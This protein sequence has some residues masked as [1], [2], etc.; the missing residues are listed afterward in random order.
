MPRQYA[1][2]RTP[3]FCALFVPSVPFCGPF[4]PSFSRALFVAGLQPDGGRVDAVA[5]PGGP[6]A[7]GENV[8]EMAPARLAEHLGASHAVAQVHLLGDALPSA[9]A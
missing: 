7:V 8:T 5:Q 4:S 9:G 2:S 3:F 1:P 6:G